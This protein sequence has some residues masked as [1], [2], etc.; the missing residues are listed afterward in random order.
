MQQNT[1]YCRRL[2]QELEALPE[3][4]IPG[5]L[6]EIIWRNISAQAYSDWLEVEIKII[7]EERLDL[8]EEAEQ[9]RLFRQM[10]AYLNLED[11]VE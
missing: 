4:P 11:L 10:L 9:E 7:N 8:S 3:A 5:S 2:K 1:V 6:G